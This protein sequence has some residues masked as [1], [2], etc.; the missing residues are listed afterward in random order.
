MRKS[1]RVLTRGRGTT[2]PSGHGATKAAHA[3]RLF[4][5]KY[6]TARSAGLQNCGAAD[7][8]T[9]AFLPAQPDQFHPTTVEH[10]AWQLIT[11]QRLSANVISGLMT[12]WGNSASLVIG[13]GRIFDF[14]KSFPRNTSLAEWGTEQTRSDAGLPTMPAFTHREPALKNTLPGHTSTCNSLKG[15]LN[16]SEEDNLSALSLFPR[17]DTDHL[18]ALANL[19]P[20]S[21]CTGLFLFLPLPQNAVTHCTPDLLN[22]LTRKKSKLCPCPSFSLRS[23][24]RNCARASTAIISLTTEVLGSTGHMWT[25]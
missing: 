9:P 1:H 15:A 3:S 13:R 25:P 22:Q 5:C 12:N 23:T 19:R 8:P 24:T 18:R 6:R 16:Q 10:A 20:P 4:C 21:T 2:C 17:S 14:P 11:R 7:L